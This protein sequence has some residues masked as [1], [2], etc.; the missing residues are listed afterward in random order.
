M[1]SEII[2]E[3]IIFLMFALRTE[4]KKREEPCEHSNNLVYTEV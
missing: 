3:I 4:Y 1:E 2:M